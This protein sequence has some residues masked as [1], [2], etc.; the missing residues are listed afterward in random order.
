M[1]EV[2]K[3]VEGRKTQTCEL[4]LVIATRVCR[5]DKAGVRVS[6]GEWRKGRRKGS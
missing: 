2:G 1:Y 3:K 5:A 6:N 4:A